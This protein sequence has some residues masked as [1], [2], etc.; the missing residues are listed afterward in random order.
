M[1]RRKTFSSH[2]RRNQV[3]AALRDEK[4]AHSLQY[5]TLP[6]LA[7]GGCS[8]SAPATRVPLASRLQTRL[9]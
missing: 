1:N 5:S 3:T 7:L 2:F 9:N 6:F 8:L 4:G